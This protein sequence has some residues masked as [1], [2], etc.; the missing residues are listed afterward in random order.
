[1]PKLTRSFKNYMRNLN[2]FRHKV[3]KVG[4]QWDNLSK[5][6]ISSAK[7]FI[8]R[9]YLALLS[10]TC[11]KIH[12]ILCY[13]W[14]HNLFF[15]TQLVCIILDY[16]WQKYPIKVQ[17]FRIFTAP[18]KIH[19]ISHVVF[20]RKSEFFFEVWITCQCHEITLLHFFSWNVICYWQG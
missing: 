1:M 18:V 19:Q 8:Q 20:H 6:Y 2:N 4:I 13:F 15:M 10:T 17:I 5:K 3:Q 9:I 14:N 12:Q 16:F 7:T 11:M